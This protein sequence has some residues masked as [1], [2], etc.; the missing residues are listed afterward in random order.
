MNFG[1]K[2]LVN[3][4]RGVYNFTTK[5]YQILKVACVVNIKVGSIDWFFSHNL[6]IL[7][8]E[9]KMLYK[10]LDKALFFNQ[11]FHDGGRYHIETEIW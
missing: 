6:A 8:K 2:I 7:I 3:D 9:C 5:G 1:S 11:L 4:Q 10:S